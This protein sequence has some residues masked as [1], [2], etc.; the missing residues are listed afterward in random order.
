MKNS[1]RRT[2]KILLIAPHRRGRGGIVSVVK[3]IYDAQWPEGYRF[4]WLATQDD[5]GLLRNIV[6]LIGAL[7]AVPWMILSADLI[8]IHTASYNSFRRKSLF[9]CWAILLRKKYILHIHGGGFPVFMKQ[10]S[11]VMRKFYTFILKHASSIVTLS[12]VFEKAVS[13]YSAAGANQSHLQIPNLCGFPLQPPRRECTQPPVILFCGWLEPEKGVFDLLEA[14]ARCA[15][16][17]WRL[18][19]AGKGDHQILLEAAGKL[20]ITG[21]LELRSWQTPEQLSELY[22]RSTLLALP[23]Y[24]EGMPMVILEAMAFG[25]PV[26]ASTVGAIP[27]MLPASA[28]KFLHDPGDIEALAGSMRAIINDLDCQMKLSSAMQQQFANRYTPEK[29]L[30]IISDLYKK[31]LNTGSYRQ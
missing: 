23:S 2:T 25:L 17:D 19:M 4:R 27:D 24:T 3:T 12:N 8:H 5:R 18:I 11:G 21:Q 14:F 15:G 31:N 1:P 13:Q 16:A 7:L 28:Q 6:T 29:I 9:V 10:A 30:E 26:I 22:Q 20:N